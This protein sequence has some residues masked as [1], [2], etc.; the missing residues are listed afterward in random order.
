[1]ALFAVVE[2]VLCA[3]YWASGWPAKHLSTV[4]VEQ[5]WGI[6]AMLLSFALAGAMVTRRPLAGVRL[7]LALVPFYLV[8]LVPPVASATGGWE[9]GW[10]F[11]LAG[12]AA[13]AAAGTLSV[14]LFLRWI[15]PEMRITVSVRAVP[16]PGLTNP[17]Q[18]HLREG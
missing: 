13:G 10:I 4:L 9:G 1:V 7:P 6:G 3:F 15:L 18:N 12:A 2:A 14:W 8:A 5:A 17:A 16:P 11:G